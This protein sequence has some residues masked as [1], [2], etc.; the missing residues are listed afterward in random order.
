MGMC[1][2]GLH[3]S[4]AC[5]LAL[6]LLLS[7]CAVP[8]FCSLNTTLSSGALINRYTT[9]DFLNAVCADGNVEG[10]R[11][12]RDGSGTCFKRRHI[13]ELLYC[14]LRQKMELIREHCLHTDEHSKKGYGNVWCLPVFIGYSNLHRKQFLRNNRTVFPKC[15]QVQTLLSIARGTVFSCSITTAHSTYSPRRNGQVWATNTPIFSKQSKPLESRMKARLALALL[16]RPTELPFDRVT[17]PVPLPCWEPE[18]SDAEAIFARTGP[19]DVDDACIDVLETMCRLVMRHAFRDAIAESWRRNHRERG[20]KH[21]K[22]LDRLFLRLWAERVVQFSLR[23]MFAAFRLE[24]AR[25]RIPQPNTSPV[26]CVGLRGRRRDVISTITALIGLVLITWLR[27]QHYAL[28][29]TLSSSILN[30]LFLVCIP[31]LV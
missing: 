5:Q 16:S 3:T 17:S 11:R 12:A 22:G 7:L 31:L 14:T 23:P 30:Q 24:A 26:S 6:L 8:A 29:A 2:A 13:A 10:P 1:K 28:K 25:R 21:F 18:L 9:A 27:V 15:E 20:M 4:C 19:W